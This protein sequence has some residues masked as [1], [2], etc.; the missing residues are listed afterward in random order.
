MTNSVDT[1]QTA[2]MGAIWSGFTL[3]AQIILSEYSGSILVSLISDNELK[4]PASI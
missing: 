4:M 3:F 1:D 2:L